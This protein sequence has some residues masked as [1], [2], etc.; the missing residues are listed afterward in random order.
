MRAL[1]GD[2]PPPDPRRRKYFE[3]WCR[4][5][6]ARRAIRFGDYAEQREAGTWNETAERYWPGDERFKITDE[7]TS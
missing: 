5:E 6:L 4:M 1:E 7:R 3:E 2:G